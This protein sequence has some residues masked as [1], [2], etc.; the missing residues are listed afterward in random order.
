M[1][2]A[3]NNLCTM[4][5]ELTRIL[6]LPKNASQKAIMA[7]ATMLAAAFVKEASEDAENSEINRLISQSAGSLTE[8]QARSVLKTRRDFALANPNI[9]NRKLPLT[10]RLNLASA[11]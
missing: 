5:A 11:A 10:R 8:R 6:G 1:T 4:K 2:A 9:G 3:T 7:R